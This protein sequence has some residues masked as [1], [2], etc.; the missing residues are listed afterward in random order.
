MERCIYARKAV[1]LFIYLFIYLF[2]FS[3]RIFSLFSLSPFA[4]IEL[5]LSKN[6]KSTSG[7]EFYFQQ[8]NQIRFFILN[9]LRADKTFYFFLAKL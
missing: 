2:S 1:F 4:H 7:L 9:V 5:E 6:R 3:V 8:I